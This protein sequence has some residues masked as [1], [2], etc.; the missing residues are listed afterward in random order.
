MIA[1][2][3]PKRALAV[4]SVLTTQE[5]TQLETWISTQV[6]NWIN[7]GHKSFILKDL[8]GHQ[9]WNWSSNNFPI[10]KLYDYWYQKYQMQNPN[11]TNDELRTWSYEAAGSSVGRLLKRVCYYSQ[12]YTFEERKE[13]QTIR[14]T[15]IKINT[16]NAQ[17]SNAKEN[18]INNG[19]GLLFE[20]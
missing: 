4:P 5:I 10:Q 8:F 14:Y 13:F 12:K 7:S 6:D 16:V 17:T 19:Q 1:N 3:K 9:Y 20:V 11:A 18:D 15:L 2:F